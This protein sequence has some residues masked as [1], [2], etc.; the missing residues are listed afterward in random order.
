[1]VFDVDDTPR[2]TLK[3]NVGA[4]DTLKVPADSLAVSGGTFPGLNAGGTAL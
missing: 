1:M 3:V 4:S 2:P